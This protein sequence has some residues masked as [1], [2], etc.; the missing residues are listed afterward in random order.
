MDAFT[1]PTGIASAAAIAAAAGAKRIPSPAT[2]V[3]PITSANA[4]K[5]RWVPTTG[6]RSSEESIVPVSDPAVEIA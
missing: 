1:V 5:V 2:A 3:T 4:R 6:I